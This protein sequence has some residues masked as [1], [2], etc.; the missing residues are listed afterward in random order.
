MKIVKNEEDAKDIVQ[1]AI[2]RTLSREC[3]KDVCGY[4]AITTRNLS[5]TFLKTNN[6]FL[7][8]DETMVVTNDDYDQMLVI[9]SKEKDKLPERLKRV[10][11]LYDVEEYTLSEVAEIMGISRATVKRD[12][13]KAHKILRAA[14]S[15]ELGW[16]SQ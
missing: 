13:D 14:I 8:L 10:V 5:F 4:C 11:E 12:V 2:A 1:E 15:H 16:Q 6:N 7:P 9:V 3:V